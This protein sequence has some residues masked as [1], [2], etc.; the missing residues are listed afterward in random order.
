V[1][2]VGSVS[3]H[4]SLTGPTY[5]SICTKTNWWYDLFINGWDENH[6]L[7]TL[8]SSGK[9]KRVGQL[10]KNAMDPE[11]ITPEGA[12]NPTI[13][14]KP[15]TVPLAKYLDGKAAHKEEVQTLQ[16]RIEELENAQPS[17][18]VIKA[19]VPEDSQSIADAI[20]ADPEAVEMI[21]AAAAA[22]NAPQL[23][24][25]AEQ[26]K[27]KKADDALETLYAET[28][29]ANPEFA[30]AN[31][32]IIKQLALNPRNAQK[33]MTQLIEETYGTVLPGKKTM[34]TSNT[35]TEEISTDFSKL[36]ENE[37]DSLLSTPDGAAKYD[38]FLMANM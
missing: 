3:F 14:V 27:A 25:I 29:K 33:T 1:R 23:K 30:V 16:A 13:E 35:G 37:L 5:H 10:L 31:K 2:C 28:V 7:F 34:E 26:E 4:P 19:T 9:L 22:R 8:S 6:K 36:S 38:K 12:E 21:L 24:K 32:E 18:P 20:G 15:E 11:P 17:A